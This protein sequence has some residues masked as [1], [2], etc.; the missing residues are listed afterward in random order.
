MK[1][2][3]VTN[4]HVYKDNLIIEY[5]DGTF[6]ATCLNEDEEVVTQN[7]PSLQK[8]QEWIDKHVTNQ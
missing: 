2:E 7:C 3:Q 6:M 8:A 1:N 5:N 4:E